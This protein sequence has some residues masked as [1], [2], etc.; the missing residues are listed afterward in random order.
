MSFK[1]CS[2]IVKSS[3]PKTKSV[4]LAVI[5]S[6]VPSKPTE[7]DIVRLNFLGTAIPDGESGITDESIAAQVKVSVYFATPL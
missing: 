2:S 4:L 1:Y 6:E 5:L 7:P 3:V